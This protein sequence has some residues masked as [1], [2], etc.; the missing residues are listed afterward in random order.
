MG[1]SNEFVVQFSGLKPG[2]HNFEFKVGNS[3]FEKLEFSPFKKGDVLV[4]VKMEKKSSMLILEFD[5]SGWIQTNCDRCAIEYNQTISGEHQIYVKFGDDFEELDD[6]LLVIPH[7]AYEIDIS[8]LIY[9]FIGLSVP[10]RNVPCEENEDTS[11][12]DQ[13]TLKHWEN[14]DSEEKKDNP[15]WAK[16]NDI[17]DQLED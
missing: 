13:E 6:N 7:E 5:L 3:F 2:I 12:C 10:L 11:I 16:L 14:S 17:K 15:L 1:K 4:K 8:Q 9:E